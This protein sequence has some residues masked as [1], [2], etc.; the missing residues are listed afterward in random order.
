[1]SIR[2]NVHWAT[3]MLGICLVGLMSIRL[4]SV[5]CFPIRLLSDL[6]TVWSG[7]CLVGLP[8]I[9]LLSFRDVSLEKCQFSHCLV[10]FLSGYQP[11]KIYEKCPKLTNCI[12]RIMLVA[13]RDKVIPLN[14]L[15]SNGVMIPKIQNLSQ[16]NVADY[17]QIVILEPG[18]TKILLT[19]SD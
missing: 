15:F 8:S 13:V 19:P 5:G 7:Y 4:L 3:A 16:P 18:S 10:G 12:S 6:V 14:W 2:V 11:Y 9:W 1:M 17:R